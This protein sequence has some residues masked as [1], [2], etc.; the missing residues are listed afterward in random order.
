M[1][2]WRA[3]HALAV[4]FLIDHELSGLVVMPLE[5]PVK[6]VTQDELDDVSPV[7]GARGLAI[8]NRNE[9]WV[10]PRADARTIPHEW[11]H[12][13]VITEAGHQWANDPV[14][15]EFADFVVERLGDDPS[16]GG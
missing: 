1:P 13:A 5:P 4:E 2:D 9:I 3:L 14:A 11:F 10:G 15:E 7:P 6:R 8:L 12:L 16:G